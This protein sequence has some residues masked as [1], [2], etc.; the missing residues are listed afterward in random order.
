M[1]DREPAANGLVDDTENREEEDLDTRRQPKSPESAH[2]SPDAASRSADAKSEDAPDTLPVRGSNEGN[3]A[4]V[5]REEVHDGRE[6]GGSKEDD[7][8]QTPTILSLIHI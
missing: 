1:A 4:A 6:E 7:I 2:A 8:E 3:R 5:V